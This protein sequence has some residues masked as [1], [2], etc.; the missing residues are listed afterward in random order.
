MKKNFIINNIYQLLL[1]IAPIIT[2][3]YVSRVLGAQGVGIYSYTNSIATYFTM[4]AALGTVSYGAREIARIRE[5]KSKTSVLFW[6]IELLTIFTSIICILIW[7]GVVIFSQNYK[8]YLLILTLNLVNVIFDISWLYTGL[9]KFKYMVRQNTVFKVLSIIALF[10]FVKDSND[11]ETYILIMCLST[12]LGSISMWFYLP[13]FINSVNVKNINVFKHFKETLIYF[14]PT[15]ATSVYTV[16]DKTLIGLITSNDVENGYYEQANKIINICKS[17]TFTSLNSVVGVRISYLYAKEKID[18]IKSRI[19]ISLD[20]IL[21]MGFGIM[22][23]LIGIVD[24]FVPIFFGDGYDEV[25]V[26]IKMLSPILLIIGISNCLGTQYYTPA[27]YRKKSAIYIIIG[28]IINLIINLI[29]IP[30]LWG[31]GAIIAS[32]IAELTIT[33][34]FLC[35]C[36][37]IIK[38]SHIIKKAWKKAVAGIFMLCV[39]FILDKFIKNEIIAIGFESLCGFVTY[40]LILLITKDTFIKYVI[41]KLKKK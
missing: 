23:G 34:L 20:Y 31:I 16:L 35:N 39:I 40:I 12:L 6:E 10:I 27:G 22:F 26:F 19:Y 18:E 11:V 3:P 32:I 14:I 41:E 29:L 15:I 33:L 37:D 28:A 2:A 4:F 5:D 1:I 9:E 24:K 7:L 13:K 30:I 36:E 8:I 38:F 21:F 17:L 25:S